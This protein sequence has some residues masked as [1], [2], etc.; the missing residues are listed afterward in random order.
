MNSSVSFVLVVDMQLYRSLCF[1]N[2]VCANLR[3]VGFLLQMLSTVLAVALW[4]AKRDLLGRIP[5]GEV[6][7]MAVIDFFGGH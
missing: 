4:C 5:S 6:F 3:M 1:C 7:V 2:I